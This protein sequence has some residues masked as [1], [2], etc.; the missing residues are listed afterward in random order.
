M[1][2]REEEE[3]NENNSAEKEED[4]LILLLSAEEVKDW[5]IEEAA[6]VPP[7]SMFSLAPM[8]R[9][10]SIG[11]SLRSGRTRTSVPDKV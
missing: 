1:F 7:K 9:T 4:K 10:I 11:A 3:E 5:Q 6:F 8:R 2:V